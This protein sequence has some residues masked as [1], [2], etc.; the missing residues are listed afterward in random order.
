M[1]EGFVHVSDCLAGDKPTRN[2]DEAMDL[3][4]FVCGSRNGSLYFACVC[5]VCLDRQSRTA[6]L[7][8]FGNSRGRTFSGS[9]VGEDDIGAFLRKTNGACPA[10]IPAGA[11]YNNGHIGKTLHLKNL[12]WLELL[13]KGELETLVVDVAE[14]DVGRKTLIVYEAEDALRLL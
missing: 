14:I 4:E 6:K 13:G 10:D 3:T 11:G 1:P 8:D 9:I 12:V 2:M 7:F 5:Q